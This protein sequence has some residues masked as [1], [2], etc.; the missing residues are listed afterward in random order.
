[1]QLSKK[2]MKLSSRSK[3]QLS[4]MY[5]L[6][7]IKTTALMKL[8]MKTKCCMINNFS[9]KKDWTSY[10]NSA[11]HQPTSSRIS[12]IRR[13][14]TR[15]SRPSSSDHCVTIALIQIATS[16]A[17]MLQV[18]LICLS[19]GSTTSTR[20]V[21]WASGARLLA[22]YSESSRRA[23]S[24]YSNPASR[25]SKWHRRWLSSLG[26]KRYSQWAQELA[27]SMAK[28]SSMEQ[29]KNLDA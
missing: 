25:P 1:M 7:Q 26:N 23:S 17:L 6:Q 4:W 10:R 21:I 11:H 14:S 2:L 27:Q 15:I 9:R 16:H 12:G 24:M 3:Q 20:R 22:T 28:R 19:H 8:K 18:H 29:F 13:E 5:P